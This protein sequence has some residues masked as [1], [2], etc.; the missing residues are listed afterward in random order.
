M[1][2]AISPA[3]L[4]GICALIVSTTSLSFGVLSYLRNRKSFEAEYRARI[5][6]ADRESDGPELAS[7][8]RHPV[9]FSCAKTLRNVGPK[10]VLVHSMTIFLAPGIDESA[11]FPVI[12]TPANTHVPAGGSLNLDLALDWRLVEDWSRS[13]HCNYFTCLYIIDF[14]RADGRREQ[15]KEVL[16]S[17]R[18]LAEDEWISDRQSIPF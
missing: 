5:S 12:S 8:R 1:P 13:V 15:I 16:G 7:S 9:A 6:V 3:V 10:P 2:P 18:P 14:E 17:V 4:T 11:A